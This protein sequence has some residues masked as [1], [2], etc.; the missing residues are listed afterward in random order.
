WLFGTASAVEIFLVPCGVIALL[1]FRPRERLLGLALTALAFSLFLFL[2]DAYGP[3]LARYDTDEY[4]AL[5]RLNL[6]SAGMLTAFVALLFS[7]LLAEA[8]QSADAAGRKKT[9]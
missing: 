2:H 8:E 5:A 4:D 3:P 7:G 9:G 6:M 1:L